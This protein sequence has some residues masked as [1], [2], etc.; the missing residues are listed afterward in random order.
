ME[1]GIRSE[2]LG[3]KKLRITNYELRISKNNSKL[4]TQNLKLVSCQSSVVS[5]QSKIVSRKSSARKT[6]NSKLFSL[7]ILALLVPL[8]A[9]S[10]QPNSS[11][12]N[13][14]SFNPNSK[15]VRIQHAESLQNSTPNTQHL[16]PNPQSLFNKGNEFYQKGDYVSAIKNYQKILDSGDESAGLYYNLG[17]CYYKLNRTADAIINY[18]RAKLLAP[19]DDDIDFNL[20]IANLRTVDRFQTLPTLFLTDWYNSIE[21]MFSSAGWSAI[22][23]I[24]LWIT[25]LSVA[26]YMI[27]WSVFFRKI[28]FGTAFIALIF[29]IVSLFFAGRVYNYEL[30]KD[31]AIV[32]SPSAY[33]KS[34][35]DEKSTDLFILHE[36]TKVKILDT[37]GD[38]KKIKLAN[39]S[40]G[41]I[42]MK[43]IEII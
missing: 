37:V 25:V 6:Q 33:V 31:Q 28:F 13:P 34:S 8:I 2:G 39:G 42:L 11:T 7:I 27:V 23:T 32:Y 18:E 14:K 20:K 9:L 26:G 29:S 16:T 30:N 40:I 36:G 21:N 5:R 22:M 1:L 43:E 38:W 15:P 3:V 17:N 24:F 41:W 10:Q 12:P 4:K 19:G 35:P